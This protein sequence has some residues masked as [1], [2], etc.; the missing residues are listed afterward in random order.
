MSTISINGIRSGDLIISARGNSI[1]DFFKDEAMA[2]VRKEVEGMKEEEIPR[3]SSPAPIIGGGS[4]G[5]HR[6]CGTPTTPSCAD[7]VKT[8]GQPQLPEG[9]D[10]MSNIATPR[11]VLAADIQ[12]F[13]RALD[14]VLKLLK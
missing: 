5:G 11:L 6:H 3:P 10:L 2:K 7:W 9:A 13:N 4:M 1:W 8:L 14:A 12:G